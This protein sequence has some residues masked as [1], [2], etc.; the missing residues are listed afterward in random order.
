MYC[1]DKSL[2]VFEIDI[3]CGIAVKRRISGPG[4]NQEFFDNSLDSWI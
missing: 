2:D 3:F 1:V 4:D